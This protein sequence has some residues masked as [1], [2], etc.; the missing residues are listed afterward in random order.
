MMSFPSDAGAS[1]T[2]DTWAVGRSRGDDGKGNL[3]K[4]L[5]LCSE[6]RWGEVPA[7]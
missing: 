5:F 7:Q 2:P 1:W 3:T 6:R 4:L